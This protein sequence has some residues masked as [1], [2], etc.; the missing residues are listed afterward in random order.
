MDRPMTTEWLDPE[1]E[2]G[3]SAADTAKG[4]LQRALLERIDVH[5]REGTLPTSGRFLFYELVQAGVVS[6]AAGQ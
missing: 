6:K 4:R 2:T 1:D 5:E 3:L